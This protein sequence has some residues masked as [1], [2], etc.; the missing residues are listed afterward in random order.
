MRNRLVLLL[1]MVI[2]MLSLFA[3]QGGQVLTGFAVKE[4][5]HVISRFTETPSFTLSDDNKITRLHTDKPSPRPGEEFIL[6]VDPGRN[7]VYTRGE[8]HDGKGRFFKYFYICGFSFTNEK[9]CISPR[10]LPLSLSRTASSR[11]NNPYTLSVVDGSGQKVTL[12]ISVK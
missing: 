9:K 10:R 1:G 5:I 3:F 12:D 4:R 7:G 2:M 6:V 8:I 11:S